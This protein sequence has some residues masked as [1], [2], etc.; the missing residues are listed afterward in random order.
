MFRV[1]PS[2]ERF[3]N[4]ECE[5]CAAFV[6]RRK[7]AN[8]AVFIAVPNITDKLVVAVGR[9]RNGPRSTKFHQARFIHSRSGGIDKKE[10]HIR[11][12]AS[13]LPCVQ[14]TRVPVVGFSGAGVCWVVFV[15]PE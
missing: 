14:T 3:A 11:F 10:R 2:V 9:Q 13:W 5:W 8:D 4:V 12:T 6:N 15:V 1:S 7:E